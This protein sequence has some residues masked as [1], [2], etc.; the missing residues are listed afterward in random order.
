MQETFG[1]DRP[2]L[3]FARSAL[4]SFARRRMGLVAAVQGEVLGLVLSSL[5]LSCQ[6]LSYSRKLSLNEKVFVLS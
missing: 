4:L 6:S 3:L 2:W 1:A 5:C